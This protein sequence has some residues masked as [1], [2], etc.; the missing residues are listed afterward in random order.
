MGV[1][2]ISPFWTRSTGRG[3]GGTSLTSGHWGQ[4]L[5]RIQ[6][7]IHHVG[8]RFDV[9]PDA[10]GVSGTTGLKYRRPLKWSDFCC[11]FSADMPVST[12]NAG[13]SRQTDNAKEKKNRCSFFCVIALSS[14][15]LTYKSCIVNTFCLRMVSSINLF[16]ILNS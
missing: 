10:S 11:T 9:W 7:Q 2:L 8:P 1:T 14:L 13:I 3:P 12:I 4:S 5:R 15:K 6:F 16:C